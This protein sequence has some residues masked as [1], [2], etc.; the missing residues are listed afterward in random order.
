MRGR[1]Q[2]ISGGERDSGSRHE[3]RRVSVNYDKKLP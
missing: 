3:S 2:E 1:K